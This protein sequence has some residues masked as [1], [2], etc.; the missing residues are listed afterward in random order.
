MSMELRLRNFPSLRILRR[1]SSQYSKIFALARL[2]SIDRLPSSGI[3]NLTLNTSHYEPILQR[4]H[5]PKPGTTQLSSRS[6][7]SPQL[8][9]S[10]LLRPSGSFT[11]QIRDAS[12]CHSRRFI[13]HSSGPASRLF[14]PGLLPNLPCLRAAR[15][16]RASAAE[17][18]SPVRSQTQCRGH[19]VCRSD[20]YPRPSYSGPTD[21]GEDPTSLFSP[22]SSPQSRTSSQTTEKKTSRIIA[23][24][25][26][27][28]ICW[29]KLTKIFANRFINRA[30]T[31]EIICP[32]CEWVFCLG[33]VLRLKAPKHRLPGHRLP[34]R[35]R[36]RLRSFFTLSS[37]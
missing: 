9:R 17:A 12:Q 13:C 25:P 36:R 11:G 26:W 29:F 5:S 22:N 16:R 14:P 28:P 35:T 32:C 23:L 1:L 6:R 21:S 7:S 24:F 3:I 10:R 27:I 15:H 30:F 31:P 33:P 34:V 2:N 20:A 18:G 37:T 4:G 8:S 19:G